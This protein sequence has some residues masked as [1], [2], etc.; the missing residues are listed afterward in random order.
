MSEPEPEYSVGDTRREFLG[1]AGK[2]VKWATVGDLFE[3]IRIEFTDGSVLIVEAVV[4]GDEY[5]ASAYLEIVLKDS[6]GRRIR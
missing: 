4:A 1:V 2:Q 5:D 6:Q 3:D